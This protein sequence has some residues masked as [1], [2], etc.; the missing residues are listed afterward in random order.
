MRTLLLAV[1]APVWLLLSALFFACGEFASKQ[2]SFHP[3][4][5]LTLLTVALYALGSLLWLPALLH[6][7]SL[8]VMGM[9]WLLLGTVATVALGLLVFHE[10]VSMVK[11]VGIAFSMVSLVLLSL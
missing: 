11:G 4:I 9:A 7:N 8:A 6:N 2:W 1:P 3:S 5:G 10:K